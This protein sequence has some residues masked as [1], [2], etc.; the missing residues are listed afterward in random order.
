ML[1]DKRMI[2]LRCNNVMHLL[3]GI[4][5]YYHKYKYMCIG[6]VYQR[7]LFWAC[8]KMCGNA[9]DSWGYTCNVK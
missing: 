2:G 5:V 4:V 9:S 8:L 7:K 1:L 6:Y 3:L